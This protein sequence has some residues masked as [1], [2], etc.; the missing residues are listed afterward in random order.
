[1]ALMP[2][3]NSVVDTPA[4]PYVA[5][6]IVIDDKGQFL[7]S[8]RPLHKL[9]GGYWEFPGG[10]IEPNETPEI[11]LIR[12]LQEE[13]GI[14]TLKYEKLMELHHQSVDHEAR[15][16]VFV[17]RD[18]EGTAIALE[19]QEICWIRKEEFSEYGFLE[20]NDAIIARCLSL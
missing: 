12:E 11:A 8:K 19:N 2:H 20:A 6:G 5:V 14:T 3:S 9:K 1:M 4:C 16:V 7:I 15:L 17:I 18:F 13:V 10:K